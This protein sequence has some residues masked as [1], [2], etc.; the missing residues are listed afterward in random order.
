MFISFHNQYL[1]KV[2][3]FFSSIKADKGDEAV[4]EIFKASRG[5]FMSLKRCL[6]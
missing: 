5:C 2:L 4:G 1:D 3:T 6:T